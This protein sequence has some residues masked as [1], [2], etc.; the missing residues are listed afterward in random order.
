MKKTVLIPFVLIGVLFWGCIEDSPIGVDQHNLDEPDSN[1]IITE[2]NYTDGTDFLEGYYNGNIR[3]DQV[4]L[5]WEASKDENFLAYKIFSASGGYPGIEYI[6]EGFEG[7]TLPENWTEWTSG[8]SGWS[9]SSNYVYNGNFSIHAGGGYF[10]DEY[11]EVTIDVSQNT[12]ID[13][14]FYQYEDDTSGDGVLY[15]NGSHHFDWDS[16]GGWQLK[17]TTYNTGSN[18]QITLQWRYSTYS[19]GD[20]YLD[21]IQVSW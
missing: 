11:L 14:S 20:V 13:I 19:Y 12:Y 4:T 21:N 17:S 16:S 8:G 3:S 18:S 2:S 6:T 10:D 1:P 15:I 5:E 9:I 7:G